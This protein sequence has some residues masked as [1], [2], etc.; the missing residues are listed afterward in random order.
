MFLRD[1]TIALVLVSCLSTTIKQSKDS[2]S[3][4]ACDFEV[5]GT[6]QGVYF[7]HHTQQQAKKLNLVGWVKNTEMDTVQGHMQGQRKHVDQ[8]KNWLRT[9]GSPKSK[10]IKAEFSKEKPISQLD[11]DSFSIKR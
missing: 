4:R 6:V 7:R 8:M 9:T 10:I 5:F 2:D 11:G 1:L 3:L